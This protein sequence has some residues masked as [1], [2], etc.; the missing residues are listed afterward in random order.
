MRLELFVALACVARAFAI[1]PRPRQLTKGSTALRLSPS[2]EIDLSGVKNPSKDLL[3]ATTR[4]ANHLRRDKLQALLVDRGASSAGRIK[5]AKL[6]VRLSLRIAS[7][8]MVKSISDEAVAPLHLRNEGYKLTVPEDGT[9]ATLEAN[10]TLGLFRGLTTFEQL[11]YELNGDVYTLEAPFDIVDSPAYLPHWRYQTDPRCNELGQGALIVLLK[12]QRINISRQLNTFHWHIV[13]SQS[14]PLQIPGFMELSEKAAY[15]S[16]A[17]YTP[18]D[19]TDI[20]TYAAERGIDVIAEIDTP[21]H[22]SA[23]SKSHPEHITCP[24]A[25]PWSTYANEPPAG[26]LRLA[27][28]ATTN[29]TFELLSAAASLFRSTYFGTGGDEVNENCY[30][31]DEETQREL[32]AQGK[33]LLEAFNTFTRVTHQALRRVGK[34]PMVWEEMLLDYEMTLANDTLIMVWISAN[35]VASVVK[36]GYQVIHASNEYFYLDCGAGGWLGQNPLGNSWCNPFKTWQKAYTFDPLAGLKPSEYHLVLG[37]Q[38]LLWTEQA[39]PS[40]LDSIT[41]PRAATSAEV[42]WSGPR[43]D[44]GTALP[45]LHDIAYRFKQRGV[46]AIALQPEWCVLR[47]GACDVDE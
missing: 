35:N 2:F 47:P 33:T 23:I 40:N 21:G 6:L 1:W 9:S 38:H 19:V 41:W 42:F 27:S 24:E 30:D 5:T 25:T 44:V 32:A 14:F 39:S 3:A 29:F 26:Q 36:K 12:Y 8:G 17:I 20:V 31:A 18:S 11:W 34:T 22:T 46:N 15:N 28:S 16:T 37:G 4:S 45:R 43:G 10:T 13:D 7:S